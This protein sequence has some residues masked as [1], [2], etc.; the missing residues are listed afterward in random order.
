MQKT[1]KLRIL[2]SVHQAIN[3]KIEKQNKCFTFNLKDDLLKELK[4]YE[5]KKDVR[6]IFS[7]VIKILYKYVVRNQ[8]KEYFEIFSNNISYIYGSINYDEKYKLK[9]NKKTIIMSELDVVIYP[10]NYEI[11]YEIN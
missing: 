8:N 10:Y 5:N 6:S 3:S 11:Y 7:K 2:Y 4:C 9:I 1:F